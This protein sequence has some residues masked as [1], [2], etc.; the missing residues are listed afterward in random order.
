MVDSSKAAKV[1]FLVF[2]ALGMVT[3]G[4]D[5]LDK[6]EQ[7]DTIESVK[8]TKKRRS[9]YERFRKLGP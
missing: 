4:K 6:L 3:N 8:V 9:S 5:V 7:G 1:V 2:I